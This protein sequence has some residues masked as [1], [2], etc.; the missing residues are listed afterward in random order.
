ML[1]IDRHL[2]SRHPL[3][4][5]NLNIL[6]KIRFQILKIKEK[7]MNTPKAGSPTI[8]LFQLRS[9]C[10]TSLEPQIIISFKIIINFKKQ[11]K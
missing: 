6:K 2:T 9:N 10:H 5:T 8:T 11:Y 3:S 7:I 1:H 4:A